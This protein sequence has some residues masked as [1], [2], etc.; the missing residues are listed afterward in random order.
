MCVHVCVCVGWSLLCS[1]VGSYLVLLGAAIRKKAKTE[2]TT[3]TTSNSGSSGAANV[4]PEQR[5]KKETAATSSSSS[6]SSSSSASNPFGA[7]AKSGKTFGTAKPAGTFAKGPAHGF[8]AQRGSAAGSSVTNTSKGSLFQQPARG[9]GTAP[10]ASTAKAELDKSAQEPAKQRGAVTETTAS[11]K[12][13]SSS[14]SS[15][16]GNSG[17]SSSGQ[18]AKSS[19][20]PN[21]FAALASK[22]QPC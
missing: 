14:S 12:T 19:K 9:F 11:T 22:G 6:S 1:A 16:D 10:A 5:K 20:A 18:D 17:S 3:A 13:G 7:L 2:A 15:S 8:G 21:P 4:V